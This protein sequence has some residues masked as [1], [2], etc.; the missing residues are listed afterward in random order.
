MLT[1]R[2]QQWLAKYCQDAVLKHRTNGMIV[3]VWQSKYCGKSFSTRA[4]KWSSVLKY[5]LEYPS[6]TRL[7]NSSSYG[8]Q[9]LTIPTPDLRVRWRRV[10][11]TLFAC[12][13][14]LFLK[15]IGKEKQ[16]DDKDFFILYFF[17]LS[18]KTNNA[19]SLKRQK[20]HRLLTY[21]PPSLPP[22]RPRP[23]RPP[24]LTPSPR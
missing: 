15:K 6:P 21:L 1:R 4:K 7:D 23:S 20:L 22:S 8:F 17:R 19:T 9:H 18:S 16:V 5:P 24:F 11:N 10:K 12:F 2:L 3:Y 14:S 13:G